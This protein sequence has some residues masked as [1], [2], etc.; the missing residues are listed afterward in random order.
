MGGLRSR[1]PDRSLLNL[2][3]LGLRWGSLLRWRRLL[4][5]GRTHG[6]RK[7]DDVHAE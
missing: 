4:A 7:E 1:W 5:E 6:G 2:G 3:C